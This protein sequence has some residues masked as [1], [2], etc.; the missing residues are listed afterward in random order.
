[1]AC[2]GGD[3]AG[4]KVGGCELMIHWCLLCAATPPHRPR[5]PLPP[6][7]S[8]QC[9]RYLADA[10]QKKAGRC[11]GEKTNRKKLRGG[12][13]QVGVAPKTRQEARGRADASEQ[14]KKTNPLAPLKEFCRK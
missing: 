7:P 6:T 11:A 4:L 12:G 9:I 13:I 1:M 3:L 2:V 8:S 5:S 10:A 14:A